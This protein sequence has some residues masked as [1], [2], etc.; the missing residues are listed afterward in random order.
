MLPTQ[1]LAELQSPAQQQ[2]HTHQ[3]Q[4][5]QERLTITTLLPSAAA[6][7]AQQLQQQAQWL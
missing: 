4:P 1:L 3:Q 6:V 5:L 2:I 7:A